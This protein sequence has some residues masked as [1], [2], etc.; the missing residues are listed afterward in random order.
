[1]QRDRWQFAV[2]G[3]TGGQSC[4]WD[5]HWHH[6]DFKLR[7]CGFSVMLSK[8]PINESQ[9]FV[10]H[11]EGQSDESVYFQMHEKNSTKGTAK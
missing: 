3:R 7:S 11:T 10:T 2:I 9:A 4:E 5:S 8:P 6:F 1:M